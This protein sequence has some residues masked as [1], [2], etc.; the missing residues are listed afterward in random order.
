VEY[1]YSGNAFSL[2]TVRDE[3]PTIDYLSY[4]F[5]PQ[6]LVQIR[7]LRIHWVMNG[8]PFWVTDNMSSVPVESWT[9]SWNALSKLTGLRRLY[10]NLEH[11]HIFWTDEINEGW[12]EK[13]AKLLEEAKKITAPRDF[14]IFLPNNQCATDLDFGDSHCILKVRDDDQ[15]QLSQTL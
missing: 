13:G 11:P 2:S 12:T 10:I 14:V 8:I 5:L 6:R 7:D 9:R 4:Y 3:V 1:L 15:L